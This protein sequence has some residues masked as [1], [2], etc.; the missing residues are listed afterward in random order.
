MA[1]RCCAP[2]A[3]G[4]LE[5]GVEVLDGEVDANPG[6]MRT[7]IAAWPMP[8]GSGSGVGCTSP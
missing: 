2:E 1:R 5:R 7:V 3:L 4:V 6:R 8:P